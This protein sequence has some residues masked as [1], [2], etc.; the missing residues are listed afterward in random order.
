MATHSCNGLQKKTSTCWSLTC[1]TLI[2]IWKSAQMARTGSKT[3]DWNTYTE[4][5]ISR[6]P[7][8]GPSSGGFLDG[9]GSWTRL[10]Q[11]LCGNLQISSGVGQEAHADY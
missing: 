9:F 6:D 8:L 3:K 11:S 4:A 2:T 10:W 1:R 7:R 5:R